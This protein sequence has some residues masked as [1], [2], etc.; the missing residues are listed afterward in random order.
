MTKGMV[1]TED[2]PGHPSDWRFEANLT[3]FSGPTI[4]GTHQQSQVGQQHNCIVS[5]VDMERQ[6]V[7]FKFAP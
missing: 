6:T 4:N 1:K 3:R 7:D 5:H 2:F